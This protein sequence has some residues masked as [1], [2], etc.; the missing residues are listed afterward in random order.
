MKYDLRVLDA[1]LRNDL[2]AFVEKTFHTVSPGHYH[3]NW[4]IQAIA[5]Q[6]QRVAAGRV[7]CSSRSRHGI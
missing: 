2:A 4:H 3:S 7:A 5:W 1:V 6:L